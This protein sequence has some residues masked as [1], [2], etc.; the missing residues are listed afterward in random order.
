MCAKWIGR[1]QSI[2]IA[3]ESVR[4]V[5]VAPSYWL[6]VLNF[7]FRDVPAK[8]LSEASF[9]RITGGDQS[10]V[11]MIHGEGDMEVELGDQSFGL[12]LYALLGTV[13]TTGPADTS[14]YTHEFSLANTNQHQSLSI[15]TIDP[16]GDLIY[17]LAMINSLSISIVPDSIISYTVSFLSKG[18]ASSEENTASYTS[19][20]KFVGRDLTFKLADTTGGLGAASEV[21]V[22]SLTLNIE[23]NAELSATLSTLHPEDIVNKLFTINGE[24]V[25]DYEDRT[26]FDYITSD[27]YKSVR[28]NLTGRTVITGSASTYPSWTLDL[29]KVSFDSFDPDFSLNE[30]VTQTLMFNALYSTENS[31]VINACTLVN[32]VSSY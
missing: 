27:D 25:L 18:S 12:I 15:T 4:G 2:G 3:K 7:S 30:I 24:I 10:P 9:G 26:Y 14:A 22:K 28:I 13:S 29:S 5:G 6:N 17:E 8:A 16:I 20:N 32:G 19:E 1:R 23:K 11:T 21:K 31:D